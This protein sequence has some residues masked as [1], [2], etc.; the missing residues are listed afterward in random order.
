MNA[1]KKLDKKNVIIL[2]ARV[3][4]GHYSVAKTI[5]VALRKQYGNKLSCTLV[6]ILDARYT[7]PS[8]AKLPKLYPKISKVPEIYNLL[9]RLTDGRVR[10]RL[11]TSFNWLYTKDNIAKFA[12]NA[13]D[14]PVDLVVTTFA[15]VGGLVLNHFEKTDQQTPLV[16]VVTDWGKVHSAWYDPRMAYCFVPTKQVYDN[17]VE[18]GIDPSR[19]IIVGYPTSSLFV[20]ASD[21]QRKQLREKLNWPENDFVTLLMGGEL[22]IGEMLA[23]ARKVRQRASDVFLV[24][25]CGKNEVLKR[26]LSKLLGSSQVL[27]FVSQSKVA[28]LYRAA[29]VLITKSGGATIAE[30]INSQL[31]IVTDDYTFEQEKANTDYIVNEGIGVKADSIRAVADLVEDLRSNPDKLAEMRQK[32]RDL[33]HPE[34]AE[35][36]A[37]RLGKLIEL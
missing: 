33:S 21:K 13:L 31:P 34:A 29:D 8:I 4:G 37:K 18:Q 1:I 2:Y 20:P 10:N 23:V 5:E 25:G 6:D 28:E 3:G 27:G 16:T 30:A 35:I 22:G 9:Y 14:R 11:I 12:D 32:I 17:A 24:A 36:I 7:P 19:V 26:K 15:F